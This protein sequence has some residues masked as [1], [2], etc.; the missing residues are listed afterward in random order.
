M[1]SIKFLFIA[2]LIT[3]FSTYLSVSIY[4]NWKI[5]KTIE[6][7]AGEFGVDFDFA[8]DVAKAES[9]LRPWAKGKDGGSGLYQFMPGTWKWATK[10]LYG[11]SL[12]F[13]RARELEKNVEVAMWF[14]AWI[15][16]VLEKE[17]HYSEAAVIYAFNSGIGKLREKNYRI[18]DSHRN[19][20]YNGYYQN[21]QQSIVSV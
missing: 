21:H 9:S 11:E 7:Y 20:I 14:I 19:K 10:R 18:P 15:E 12:S 4:K 2:V 6:G 5:Q 8:Y 13:N 3:L 17:G 1:R 16:N